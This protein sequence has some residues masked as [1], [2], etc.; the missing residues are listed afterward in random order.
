[1]LHLV[2]TESDSSPSPPS[3]LLVQV[4]ARLLRLLQDLGSRKILGHL[5]RLSLWD[6]EIKMKQL[7]HFFNAYFNVDG[8]KWGLKYW[9][10]KVLM[11]AS[12]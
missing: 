3:F 11:H 8:L 2:Q 12:H 5:V 6:L 10:L 1:M 7:I 4:L 9:T